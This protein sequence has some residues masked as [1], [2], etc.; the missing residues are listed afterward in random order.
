MCWDYIAWGDPLTFDVRGVRPLRRKSHP[1]GVALFGG[2]SGRLGTAVL[3]RNRRCL[4]GF[5]RG[6]TLGL[7]ALVG[8]TDFIP[9][10]G[11]ISSSHLFGS[12]RYVHILSAHKGFHVR[13][14]TG[15]SPP[16]HN[17]CHYIH[18]RP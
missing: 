3:L 1:G 15:S 16:A 12:A 10:F 8:Q 2:F 17:T 14:G 13:A 6:L 7:G 5:C 4:D 9:S 18:D 11:E